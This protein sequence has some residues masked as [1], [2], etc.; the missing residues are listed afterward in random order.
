MKVLFEREARFVVEGRDRD[1][2][3][4]AFLAGFDEEH[5]AVAHAR[6]VVAYRLVH[7]IDTEVE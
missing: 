7:V 5:K 1:G 6:D 4:W 3:E 2:D